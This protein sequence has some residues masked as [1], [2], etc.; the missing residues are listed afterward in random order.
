MSD[1]YDNYDKKLLNMKHHVQIGRVPTI[2][3]NKIR[4]I[5]LITLSLTLSQID[6]LLQYP[7]I[8]DICFWKADN[9]I[10]NINLYF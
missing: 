9:C 2:I 5:I 8:A 7:F 1:H 6:Q 10:R 4:P 3:E